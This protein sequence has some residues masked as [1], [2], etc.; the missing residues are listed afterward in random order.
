MVRRYAALAESDVTAE[1]AL[2]S[3]LDHLTANGRRP[4][5][6]AQAVRDRRNGASWSRGESR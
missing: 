6:R 3:P 2:A 5:R 1:H 4:G